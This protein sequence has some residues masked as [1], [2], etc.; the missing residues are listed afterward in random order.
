MQLE[1]TMSSP[2]PIETLS[3]CR[4]GLTGGRHVRVG[5]IPRA[6][7]EVE[8][9]ASIL[10]AVEVWLPY[11]ILANVVVQVKI[12][13]LCPCVYPA[14]PYSNRE[15]CCGDMPH[16]DMSAWAIEKVLFPYCRPL[17]RTSTETTV[18]PSS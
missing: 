11:V 1:V 4:L 8:P 15:W 3:N 5:A 9:L 12:T 7:G 18:K 2:R 17:H 14:N 16:L 13:D 10:D 6:V